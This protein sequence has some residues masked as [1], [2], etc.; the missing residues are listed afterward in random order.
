[1]A[2]QQLLT[3]RDRFAIEAGNKLKQMYLSILVVQNVLLV[4][5]IRQRYMNCVIV[6]AS[7]GCQRLSTL[8][9][10]D[11]GR[12]TFVS[13]LLLMQEPSSLSSSNKVVYTM[14]IIRGCVT[15]S[16][17]LIQTP[18]QMKGPLGFALMRFYCSYTQLAGLNP[19][20]DKQWHI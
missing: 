5:K 10:L 14:Y 7:L 1:M 16:F 4:L 2:S 13:V 8:T 19:E 9:K 18:A 20:L 15:S 6:L 17:W 11:P 3:C 12:R